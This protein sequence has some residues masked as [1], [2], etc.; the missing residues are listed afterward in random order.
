MANESTSNRVTADVEA[1][2]AQLAALRADMTR[3]ATEVS[4]S[5]AKRGQE[6][7]HD[8]QAG[9]SDAG[10]YLGRKGHDADVRLEKAVTDNPY[11]A[12]GIA[13]GVGLILGAMTRR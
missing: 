12:L 7:A 11:L 2:S 8:L 10:H 5:A 9:L 1:L 3:L 13:A 6:M 4:S